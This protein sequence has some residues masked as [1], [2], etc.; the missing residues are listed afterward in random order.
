MC[1][2]GIG[3]CHEHRLKQRKVVRLPWFVLLGRYA[4]PAAYSTPTDR[5]ETTEDS[6]E[7][8]GCYSRGDSAGHADLA[9]RR[10]IIITGE[11]GCLLCVPLS[12]LWFQPE[13][14]AY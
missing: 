8:R 4:S 6:E 3:Y 9:V 14:L 1:L 2:H 13:L 10:R 12:P 11:P 7:H 5:I